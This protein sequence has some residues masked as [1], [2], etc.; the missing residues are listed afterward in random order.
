MA[1]SLRENVI[2]KEN[3]AMA[4][5]KI[6][7]AAFSVMPLVLL[8]V[9]LCFTI[10]P[11]RTDL[12]LNFIF[13]TVMVILG[14]SFFS[15]GAEMSMT[16]IGTKIGTAMTKTK[17]LPFILAASFA[18]GFAVTVA[19][20]D[21]QVLAETV[22]HI[23]NTV[24][25][26]TVGAGVGF[27]LMLCMVRIL[28]GIK[29]RWMLLFFYALVFLLASVAD[30]N[31]L[32]IAFDSG[33][34]TTGPMTVPFIL[35]L[36]VGVS[37]IRSDKKAE[38]DSFGLVALSSIGPILAVLILGF[39]YSGE[40][41]STEQT[42][43]LFATTGE[44]GTE[45]LSALPHYLSEM[46]LS[47]MP[48]VVIF[49]L[50]QFFSLRLS[51]RSIGKILIGLLYTYAGLVLFLTGVNVG[52]SPLGTVLGASLASGRTYWLLVPLSM[53]FGWFIISA[54]PAVSVLQNQIDEVSA[55][56]I[57][58]KAIKFSLSAAVAV[59]MGLSMLRVMTGISVLWFLIPGYALA[60]ALSFF[61]P[62]IYTA[63]AF[64]SG[65]VASGPMTATFMLSFI[66]GASGA[67]GKSAVSDAFG[68]V[69]MVAMLPLISIQILG[70][71]YTR[72]DKKAVEEMPYYGDYDIVELWEE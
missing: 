39:F 17:K 44:I 11:V 35:A 46:A 1:D 27:F 36:G 37:N 60:L 56:A 52:F 70:A 7:E 61:V 9:L 24:L 64:D 2:F 67:I 28:S 20:P 54:E 13:G 59:A 47:L 49:F 50:F 33:G 18:L 22:P 6:R 62:E 71:V 65:G 41:G 45:Y 68:L 26:V 53:L 63:I 15:L 10:A 8:V 12:M 42:Q 25:L 69:A 40:G 66:I 32:G 19:E 4:A 3:R 43:K 34:V 72:K 29:L 21:L 31:F 38:A 14:M 51:R 48:I 30:K 16:P 57:P 58:K 5:E 23:N 55:G